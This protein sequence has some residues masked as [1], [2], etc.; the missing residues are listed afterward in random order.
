[1]VTAEGTSNPDLPLKGR[2]HY[3]IAESPLGAGCFGTVFKVTCL[4]SGKDYALKV[5][6]FSN[7]NEE[8]VERLWREVEINAL[9]PPHPNIVKYFT[10]WQEGHELC[11]LMEFCEGG[12]VFD[13]FVN[14]TVTIPEP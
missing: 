11:I 1:M 7:C 10:H 9:L 12:N 13:A 8:E 2:Q 4:R 3:L 6:D 5:I 14:S